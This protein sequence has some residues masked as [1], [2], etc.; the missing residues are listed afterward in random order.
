MQARSGAIGPNRAMPGPLSP[1]WPAIRQAVRGFYHAGDHESALIRGAHFNAV[2]RLTPFAMAANM[3]NGALVLWAFR[4]DLPSGLWWW[5]LGLM[6]VSAQGMLGAW[7]RRR[8]L[9]DT[10]SRRTVKHATWHAGLLAGVWGLMPMIWFPQASPSQQ[11]LIATLVTGMLG[12]GAFLLSPLPHASLAYTLVFCVAGATALWRAGDP[13]FAGVA[14]LLAFYAAIV[15]LGAVFAFRKSTALL[16]SQAEAVRHEQMLA[17]LLQDFEQHA[18][19]A[20]WETG[21]GGELKHLSPRLADLLGVHADDLR[22]R[23]LL[24]WLT[25]H[26]A[27]GAATLTRALDAGRPFRDIPVTLNLHDQRRHLTINGKP[28]MDESARTVGWR[29]VIA[30]VTDKVDNEQRLIEL[31]HT[32]SL[33]GLAN[34]VTLRSALAAA[35]AR[36]DGGALLMIDLDHFKAVND[37]LGHS[38]GDDLLGSV[39]ERLRACVRDVELVARLGGDEFAVL[40]AP[41]PDLAAPTILADRITETLGRP[42]EIQGRQVR[43]GASV[44]ITEWRDARAGVD[45]L[46]VQADTALY[47]AKEAGRGRHAFFTPSLGERSHR[48]V[49]VGEGLRHAIERGELSL[50]WQPKVDIASWHIVG[51]E[52][53]MRWTHPDLGEVAPT[54]FIAIAEQAGLIDSLGRWALR[55]AFRAA[56]GPLAGLTVSVNVSPLQLRDPSLVTLARDALQEYRASPAQLELEITESVFIDDSEHALGQL[57]ALRE[58]GLRIGLDDFG[59]G[60]SSLAYLRR[61]PFDTLKIDRAFV[62]EMLLRKDARAIVQMI[63]QLADTLGMRTVCE[64]VETEQQLTA[65][66]QAGCHEVQGYLVSTPLPI[67]AFMRFHQQWRTE[68]RGRARPRAVTNP[69]FAALA[70][71]GLTGGPAIPTARGRTPS[72]G[73]RGRSGDPD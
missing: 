17:V 7:R 61:F 70:T 24:D 73:P 14:A 22:D 57:H 31:A 51:A 6:L 26:S 21:L 11:L 42:Y 46:L 71:A 38:A 33:T 59:T 53:L 50:H 13:T 69:A 72:V 34:R 68:G 20:L 3:A 41:A 37:S 43:V 19:E 32:D 65:V 45:S 18:G 60:Y 56:A 36:G 2:G 52:A 15:M 48:R 39:A 1:E 40:L 55:E 64:G 67:G 23:S 35:L 62:N 63:S 27:D 47:A 30:D 28:L 25:T 9:R 4:A 49:T 54:E 16:R 44:G 12:A 29:G 58:L 66:A 5:W 10:A 8:I